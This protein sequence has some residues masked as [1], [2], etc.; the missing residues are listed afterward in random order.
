MN[1]RRIMGFVIFHGEHAKSMG[2]SKKEQCVF[3]KLK[4]WVLKD[5]D[6]GTFLISLFQPRNIYKR[7]TLTF[8][9]A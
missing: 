8:S 4:Q 6:V 9:L 5:T 2:H 7:H 3:K 1:E